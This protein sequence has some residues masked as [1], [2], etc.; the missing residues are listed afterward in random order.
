[1][2]VFQE[3]TADV[4]AAFLHQGNELVGNLAGN[5][6]VVLVFEPLGEQSLDLVGAAV[7]PE[8]FLHKGGD[9]CACAVGTEFHAETELGCILEQGV[10]PGGTV[11]LCVGAVRRG[12]ERSS[13]NGGTTGSVGDHHMVTEEL[14]DGL[15]VRGLAAAG[16]GARELE[17]RLCELGVLHRSELVD[18]FLVSDFAV[19][20][21]E[22]GLVSLMVDVRYH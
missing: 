13:V 16:A 8:A 7:A 12:R 21:V 9:G 18:H 15:D 1:M 11:T 17:E 22:C 19:E 3:L 10:V 20:P 4:A 2:L 5:R 6:C 14:G